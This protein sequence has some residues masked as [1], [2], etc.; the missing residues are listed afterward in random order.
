[1]SVYDPQSADY[2]EDHAK[3]TTAPGGHMDYRE[4]AVRPLRA[5]EIAPG[6]CKPGVVNGKPVAIFNVDGEFY[7][8]QANCTHLGG[9]LCE[10]AMWGHIVTCPWH[11]SEF[12]IRDGHVVTPPAEHA[13]KTYKVNVIQGEVVIEEA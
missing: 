7:A 1:M 13:V 9:P 12:D 10:G 2:P 11:G 3:H 6:T 4:D 5:D 8:T